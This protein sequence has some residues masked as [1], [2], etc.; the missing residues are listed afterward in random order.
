M[1]WFAGGVHPA[2]I[3]H[4]DVFTLTADRFPVSRYRF[5]HGLNNISLQPSPVHPEAQGEAWVGGITATQP[6]RTSYF[7]RSARGFGQLTPFITA[8]HSVGAPPP[9]C[10]ARTCWAVAQPRVMVAVPDPIA[11]SGALLG[12][13]EG[14]LEGEGGLEA[15]PDTPVAL[16]ETALAGDTVLFPLPAIC[17]RNGKSRL[18]LSR[19]D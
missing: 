7:T 9:S 19:I 6:C 10:P 8:C 15:V 14:R 3:P 4:R 16:G 13:P 18:L 17:P 5:V 11:S 1:G 12:P 2:C